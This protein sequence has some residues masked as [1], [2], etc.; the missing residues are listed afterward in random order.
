MA[1][2]SLLHELSFCPRRLVCRLV[3]KNAGP[4]ADRQ[5]VGTGSQRTRARAG[6]WLSRKLGVHL[7]LR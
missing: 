2:N 5:R 1:V 7:S 3:D 6:P 4:I